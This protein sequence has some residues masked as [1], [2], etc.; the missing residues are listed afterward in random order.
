MITLRAISSHVALALVVGAGG[1]PLLAQSA[2]SR[3]ASARDGQVRFTFTLR[4]GVCGQGQNI[5]RNGSRG[6]DGVY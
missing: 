2:A 5:W 6:R 4:P 3:I 1:V